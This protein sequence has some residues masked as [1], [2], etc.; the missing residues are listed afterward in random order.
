MKK[1][2]GLNCILLVDD[3]E[4]SNYLNRL[5]IEKS[6]V[7]VHVEVALNGFAALE[8]LNSSGQSDARPEP[9]LIFLDINMPRMNGWEFLNEY[10]KLKNKKKSDTS[11]AMLSSSIDIDDMDTALKK[12]ELPL[13]IDKPLTTSKLEEVFGKCFPVRDN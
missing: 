12:Y 1:V 7:D 2:N 8:Y 6:G 11:I 10:Q 5:V 4:I 9:D 3:D 13:Y